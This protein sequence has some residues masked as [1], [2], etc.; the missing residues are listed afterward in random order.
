MTSSF[1]GQ[2]G[3][4]NQLFNQCTIGSVVSRACTGPEEGGG[5]SIEQY[6]GNVGN[7]V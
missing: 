6:S 2:P 5:K 4:I 3:L 1:H 7:S